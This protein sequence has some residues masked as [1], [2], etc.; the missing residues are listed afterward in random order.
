MKYV[1][2]SRRVQESSHYTEKDQQS[3][4]CTEE[5]FTIRPEK[6]ISCCLSNPDRI[7][8]LVMADMVGGVVLQLDQGN[9]VCHVL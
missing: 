2:H 1:Q 4:I 3:L 5:P 8:V 7:L 9:G 6:L